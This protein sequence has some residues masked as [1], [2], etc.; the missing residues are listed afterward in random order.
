MKNITACL[1]RIGGNPLEGGVVYE[2]SE[3]RF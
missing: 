2:H 1:R 3:N